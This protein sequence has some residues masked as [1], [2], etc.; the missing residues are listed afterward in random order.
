MNLEKC[1]GPNCAIDEEIEEWVT[2]HI[3]TVLTN[4]GIYNSEKYGQDF[5]QEIPEPFGFPLTI[6]RPPPSKTYSISQTTIET[7]DNL[8]MPG[9]EVNERSFF[10][11]DEFRTL[12]IADVGAKERGATVYG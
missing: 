2:S 12:P 10:S 1:S 6:Q 4:Q 9:V 3:M 8:L 11:V 5:V 7:S